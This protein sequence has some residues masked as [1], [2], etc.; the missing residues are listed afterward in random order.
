M[1]RRLPLLHAFLITALLLSLIGTRTM[2]A[3]TGDTATGSTASS[4]SSSAEIL[5]STFEEGYG[6][7]TIEQ[8]TPQEGVYGEWTIIKP[9]NEGN[10]V[11]KKDTHVIEEAEAGN[12]TILAD[13]PSGMTALLK[14]YKNGSLVTI[15]QR[16][17][18]T[19]TL[20][21]DDTIRI[22][23][24][25][26]LSRIGAVTVSTDPSGLG[27]TLKG[28]NESEFTG[29]TPESFR[30]VPEGLYT[31]YMDE[32][33]GCPT[34]APKSGRLLKGNRINLSIKLVCEKLIKLEK[35]IEK[36]IGNFV[37]ARID[38]EE[39]TFQDV[40][41]DRWYSQYIHSVAVRGISTGYRDA[42]GK[43]TGTF[44]PSNLVNM[45]EL[46]KMAHEVAGI[47]ETDV[48]WKPT[49]K[50][51]HNTWYEQYI[52]S[53]ENE[54][55]QVYADLSLDLTRPAT[56][57]EV[58]T[59]L[60]QALDVPRAWPKGEM[61]TDVSATTKYASS[62]ETAAQQG[63]IS[64]YTNKDGSATGEFGPDNS[65]NRAEMAKMLILAIEGYIEDTP[66]FEAD[67]A[68]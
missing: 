20:N 54:G 25:Y 30:D 31:V 39:V 44:G 59:T 34:P 3:A 5:T 35:A 52:A 4:S 55:W 14:F 67:N 21:H 57:A 45:A 28:P 9:N 19:F 47:D 33:E 61:F 13:P 17:Q 1:T 68:K 62:I 42:T 43:H 58:V 38:G 64:G 6:T 16:P 65:V 10:L 56:R 66:F 53:A 50:K 8:N 7:I 41:M 49:N 23:F 40:P 12:Y 18:L 60:L 29:I 37:T 11:L 27:F 36:R 26:T 2:Y 51:A 24:D 48:R 46:A 63:F 22:R 15:I 32:I